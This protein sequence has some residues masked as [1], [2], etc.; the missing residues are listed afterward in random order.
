M[1]QLSA[2]FGLG[3]VMYRN[4]MEGGTRTANKSYFH[5]ELPVAGIEEEIRN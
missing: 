4:C 5:G 1:K 2:R 3:Y